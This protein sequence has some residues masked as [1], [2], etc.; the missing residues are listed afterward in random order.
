MARQFNGNI[1]NYLNTELHAARGTTDNVSIVFVLKLTAQA[2]AVSV[3]GMVEG[4]GNGFGFRVNQSGA[5]TILQLHNNASGRS[6]ADQTILN[7]VKFIAVVNDVSLNQ[8]RFYMGDTADTMVDLGGAQTALTFNAAAMPDMVMGARNNNATIQEPLTGELDQL[9]IFFDTV[10]TLAQIKAVATCGTTLAASSTRFYQLN[11]NGVSELDS[12]PN[13]DHA[14]IVG[15]VP[16][17]TDICGEGLVGPS[18]NEG[19]LIVCM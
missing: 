19:S 17:V 2:A 5:N 18:A 6:P 15:T 10:L 7:L 12:S 3:L 11:F 16:S 14:V 9:S 4:G 13:A 1:A 8:C